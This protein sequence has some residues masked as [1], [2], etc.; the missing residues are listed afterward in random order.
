MSGK[1]RGTWGLGVQ[2][3]A[4]DGC[5]KIFTHEL[6][7]AT[8]EFLVTFSGAKKMLDLVMILV[9]AFVVSFGDLRSLANTSKS[10]AHRL[11]CVRVVRQVTACFAAV[12]SMITAPQLSPLAPARLPV[13]EWATLQ[14]PPLH[15]PDRSPDGLWHRR[16]AR[17]D[18]LG[19]VRTRREGCHH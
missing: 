18:D 19:D 12:C 8:T 7:V 11:M 14:T 16:L 13:C 15:S 1:I 6:A 10:A 5:S 9:A 2:Q 3:S 4:E 17:H